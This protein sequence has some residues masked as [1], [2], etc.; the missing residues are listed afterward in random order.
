MI[1]LITDLQQSSHTAM[2]I[3][4]RPSLMLRKFMRHLAS[5]GASENHTSSQRPEGPSYSPESCWPYG[6][7]QKQYC[8]FYGT[9]MDQS[10]LARILQLPEPPSM[11]PARV[12]GYHV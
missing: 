2:M 10:T 7:F 8:F 3:K 6:P 1:I 9:L 4:E 5:K 11:R 12:V